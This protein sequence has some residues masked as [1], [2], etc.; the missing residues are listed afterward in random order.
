M[1]EIGAYVAIVERMFISEI[2]RKKV[3]MGEKER[4]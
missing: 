2:K 1:F 3:E 4:R